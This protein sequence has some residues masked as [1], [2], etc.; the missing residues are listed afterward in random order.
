VGDA[1][2]AGGEC[3]RCVRVGAV[4]PTARVRWSEVA[5]GAAVASVLFNLGRS[6]FGL[7][8]ARPGTA[9]AFGAAGSLAVILMWRFY[10]A[11]VFLYGVCF[12]R[13]WSE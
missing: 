8:L 7:Y 3:D 11:A 4:M 1:A 2:A 5:L 6:L 12:A 10:S 9:D 13:V